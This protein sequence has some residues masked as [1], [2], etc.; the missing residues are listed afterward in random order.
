MDAV[1]RFAVPVTL[2]VV[3]LGAC[4]PNE[5]GNTDGA[6]ATTPAT[7]SSESP[8]PVIPTGSGEYRYE[9]MGLV[10]TLD[11][12]EGTGTLE[13]EN[14]TGRDL[15]EPHFYILDGRDG[16]RVE[17]EVE[18]PAP[19]PDG[20]TATFDVGF[21]GIEVHNIGLVVLLLGTDNYGA[22]VPQ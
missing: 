2:V 14:R 11:L 1:R 12:D 7:A 6:T 15:P 19:I 20:E 16:H 21:E 10:A 18:A 13:I 22:F 5:D 4:T 17:G 8:T 9:N 3:L